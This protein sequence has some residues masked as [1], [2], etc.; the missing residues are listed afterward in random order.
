MEGFTE[1][2]IQELLETARKNP[3]GNCTCPRNPAT[4]V[5]IAFDNDCKEHNA[6]P[7]EAK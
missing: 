3:K 1:K 6:P 2:Q 7:K 5:R 4:T